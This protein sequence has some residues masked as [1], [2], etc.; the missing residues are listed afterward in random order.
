MPN[1]FE[2][3]YELDKYGE[4]EEYSLKPGSEVAAYW[5]PF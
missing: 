4:P 3:R 5:E 1:S 2:E